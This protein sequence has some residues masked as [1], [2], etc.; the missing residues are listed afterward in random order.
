M[1]ISN[2]EKQMG[3]FRLHIPTLSLAPGTV[4]GILGPNGSG[5]S[6]LL[7]L[8]GGL[9]SPD[10]GT[11]SLGEWT[12]KDVTLLPQKPYLLRDTVLQNLLYPLKL[13]KITPTQDV[14]DH[15]LAL[16]GLAPLAQSF[17]PGLSSGEGQKLALIRALI[18]DPK[19]V[20]IDE[21]FSNMDMESQMTF[22]SYI[23]EKQNTAP[24]TWVIISHQLSTIKRL[25][26][27]VIY[28]ENGHIIEAGPTQETL[29]SPTTPALAKFL[30]W[31]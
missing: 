30:A 8:L 15:Y 13:R 14:V 1:T 16:A 26:D 11:I 7:K 23:L 27:Q 20:L 12:G 28:M 6:T 9:L 31:Q 19:L 17:A 25:C 21:T 18:F 2:V 29:E 10:G 3:S 22:E 4:Y 5:K 24:I